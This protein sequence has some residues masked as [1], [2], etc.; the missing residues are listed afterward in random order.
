MAEPGLLLSANQP[1][2]T[3]AFADRLY[4]R[5]FVPETKIGRV[6]TGQ[7]AWITVDAF[8]GRRFEARVAEISPDAEFTPKPV[9]TQS[10][11]VNLVY[12]TKVDLVEGWKEP[13]VPGQPADIVV[14]VGGASAAPEKTP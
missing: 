6:R 2:L 7:R 14:E 3:L 10:E 9:E 13:L 1:A 4:A 5:T 11:R 12:S 8:P